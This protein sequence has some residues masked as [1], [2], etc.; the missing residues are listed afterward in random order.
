MTN[1]GWK[2]IALAAGFLVLVPAAAVVFLATAP[3]QR[4]LTAGISELT[5]GHVSA[6]GIGFCWP[7]T[8]QVRRLTL[9]DQK[10]VWLTAEDATANGSLFPLIRNEVRLQR[11]TARTVH[12]L[13]LPV[14]DGSETDWPDIDVNRAEFPRIQTGAGLTAGPMNFSG[15]ASLHLRDD[16]DQIA[17]NAKIQRQDGPGTYS[18]TAALENGAIDGQLH[19]DEPAPALVSGILGLNDTGP[20]RADIAASGPAAANR[21]RLNVSAGPFRASGAGI[22][23]IPRNSLDLDFSAAAPAMQLR[24]DLAWKTLAAEGHLHGHFDAPVVSGNFRVAE[25]RS[26][27]IHAASISGEANG[28]AGIASFNAAAQGLKID[29][30]ASDPFAQAPVTLRAQV[31]FDAAHL[32]V[33]FAISHPLLSATG[34]ANLD[35]SGPISAAVKLPG[36]QV[37]AAMAGLDLQGSAN[38]MTR[39]SDIRGRTAVSLTGSLSAVSGDDMLVRLIGNSAALSASAELTGGVLSNLKLALQG[40]GANA[41]VSGRIDRGALDLAASGNLKQVS[42]LIPGASGTAAFN[43]HLG[44]TLARPEATGPVTGTV[45]AGGLQP[46]PVS[47]QIAASASGGTIAG[48][49]RGRT[50]F[51]G[52]PLAASGSVGWHTHSLT[53]AIDTAQWKSLQIRGQA[54]FPVSSAAHASGSVHAGTLTDLEPW[55]G[56]RPEGSADI[57]FQFPSG[58]KS[59]SV[60]ATAQKL[61]IGSA[62]AATVT[63]QGQIANPFSASPQLSLK[64]AGTG[65]GSAG[66]TGSATGTLN[67]SLDRLE[68][69]ATGNFQDSADRPLNISAAGT[70]QG[71]GTALNLSSL[72]LQYRGYSAALASP[73]VVQM[74]G[75]ISVDHATLHAGA[76]EIRVSGELSPVLAAEVTVAGVPAAQLRPYVPE[77]T[78]GEFSGEGHLSG[79]LTAPGGRIVLTG[80]NLRVA[81]APAGIAPGTLD[82]TAQ[83]RGDAASVDA[84]LAIGSSKMSASGQIPF[85]SAGQFNLKAAGNADLSIFNTDLTAFGRRVSGQMSLDALVHGTRSAP[86]ISGTASISRGDF[87]DATA[88]VRISGIEGKALFRGNNIELQNVSAHAGAGTIN[89]NGSIDLSAPGDPV[90]LALT[91]RNAEPISTDSFKARLDADVAITGSATAQLLAKGRITVRS[92]DS[93]L[94]DSLPATVATLNVTRPGKAPVAQEPASPIRASRLA[95]DLD[96]ASPGQ[97]FIRGRG[98]DAELEGN[99]HVGGTAAAPDV[100]GALDLR[101]GSFDLG[102]STLYFTS[103]KVNLLPDSIRNGIDPALDLVAQSQAGAYATKLEITGTVSRPKVQL[104]STPSLAQDEILS[105]L[106]FQESVAQLSP[107]QLGQVAQGVATIGGLGGGFDPVSTVRRTLGLDR[108]SVVSGPNNEAQLEAGKYVTR[109]VFIGAKQGLSNSPQAEVQIDLSKH[110][111]ATANIATGT[112]PAVTQGIQQQDPGTNAGLTW[113]FEY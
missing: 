81:G 5:D 34:T 70:L 58:W 29:G 91:A 9:R 28:A 94:P 99:L 67:G 72:G 59:A 1:R 14:S 31:R 41:Q 85:G 69:T 2:S 68:I 95:L 103:G 63:A 25:F 101:R 22:A 65:V 35:G 12:V 37:F 106:L 10:G 40:S 96:V 89:I 57:Q 32:P 23:N 76:A 18:L 47:L 78:D 90:R 105:Q 54:E 93:Q 19:I 30:L 97:F 4:V 45:A 7:G 80:R 87:Q 82:V 73:A 43:L 13:R 50:V 60:T 86:D 56:A 39:I 53:V 112:N 16:A 21:F 15:T 110:L 92:G 71:H 17:I 42:L 20:L 44:G 55:L 66:V 102:G 62:I 77:L 113:Q 26:G 75:G 24:P 48:T 38:L 107:L 27:K 52:D 11:L 88:G 83:L 111:K 8:L 64:L 6:S 36:I 61:A 49:F 104:T 98:L 51:H 46:L 79:S 74:A 84:A 3:G 109:N 108:L 33:Q 100:K